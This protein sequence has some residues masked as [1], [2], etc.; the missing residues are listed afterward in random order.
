MTITVYLGEWRNSMS[1]MA[2]FTASNPLDYRY[3]QCPRHV[4]AST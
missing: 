4:S 2:K 1:T 3:I